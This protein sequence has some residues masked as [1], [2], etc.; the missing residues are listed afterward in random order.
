MKVEVIRSWEDRNKLLPQDPDIS[1]NGLHLGSNEEKVSYIESVRSLPGGN[2]AGGG[3]NYRRY[4]SYNIGVSAENL[5]S[6]RKFIFVSLKELDNDGY[7]V[8]NYNIE[9]TLDP[10]EKR[11]AWT[12]F[13]PNI[14][15]VRHLVLEDFSTGTFSGRDVDWNDGKQ[16]HFGKLLDE[17]FL[18]PSELEHLQQARARQINIDNRVTNFLRMVFRY[19]FYAVVAVLGFIFIFNVIQFFGIIRF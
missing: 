6:K 1:I 10:H 8:R 17:A 19:A 16:C 12:N 2:V 5:S 7:V 3:T 15:T 18:S 9:L 13:G 14:D 4:K 11:K